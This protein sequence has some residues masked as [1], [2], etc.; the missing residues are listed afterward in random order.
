MCNIPRAEI[1]PMLPALAGE[2]LSTV[3]PGILVLKFLILLKIVMSLFII[4]SSLS[5]M[6]NLAFISF[7]IVSCFK[8]Y[9]CNS[10]RLA[11]NLFLFMAS[12][13]SCSF[14]FSLWC[15]LHMIVCLTHLYGEINWGLEWYLPLERIGFFFLQVPRGTKHSE[16]PSV[17]F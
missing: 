16:P 9:V 15:W 13:D 1:E 10:H 17:Q 4:S 2:F 12:V 14:F 5:K 8:D 6:S 3:P 7:N 11:M